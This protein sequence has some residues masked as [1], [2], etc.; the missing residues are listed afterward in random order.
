LAENNVDKRVKSADEKMNRAVPETVRKN[1]EKMYILKGY[2]DEMK[3]TKIPDDM[4]VR[5]ANGRWFTGEEVN[6]FKNKSMDRCPTYGLCNGCSGSGPSGM[7]C[8]VCMMSN[9][10]YLCPYMG[11]FEKKWLDVEWLSCM[12]RTIHIE[13]KAD[14]VQT[15]PAM[16]MPARFWTEDC[17]RFAV[18]NAY[19]EK[20]IR[21]DHVAFYKRKP[22][23]NDM[24]RADVDRDMELF[25]KGIQT[26]EGKGDFDFAD[27][28]VV[29]VQ[30]WR[31][32]QRMNNNSTTGVCW[33]DKLQTCRKGTS[34]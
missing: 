3:G 6:D 5:A 28:E 7:H 25:R 15:Y 34:E 29:A 24:V 21:E 26:E 2:K 27:R 11:R 16:N 19:A 12:M 9:N 32:S 30:P 18:K 22:H 1:E 20:L 23:L 14:M 17:V 33:M 31:K 4:A 13:A 10:H 8:Q